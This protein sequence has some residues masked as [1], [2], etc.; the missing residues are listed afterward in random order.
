[1]LVVASANPDK[2]REMASLLCDLPLHVR[3]LADFPGVTLPPE[4]AV[5]YL[6]NALGKARAAAAATGML[7]MGDDSGLEVDA[8]GGAPGVLSARYGGEGLDDAQRCAKLLEALAGVPPLRRTARFRSVIA[9]VEPGG[10]EATAEGEAE[11][12]I[13]D[14]P[15]GTGGFGYDPLFYYPPLD[16][17][18]A[19]L[20]DREKN[21]VSHRARAMVEARAVLLDWLRAR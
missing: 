12:I 4:G 16:S 8:L 7:A 15:Q 5:S 9:L 3:P 10:R 2:A 6:D 13:L 18:F 11:G 17:A 1:V 19:Q 21:V 14:R 20:P